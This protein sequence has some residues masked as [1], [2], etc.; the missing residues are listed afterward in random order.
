MQPELVERQRAA[1]VENS[2]AFDPKPSWE[3]RSEK[4]TA[5]QGRSK[6]V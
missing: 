4:Q 1:P 6:M 2:A 5:N 3:R